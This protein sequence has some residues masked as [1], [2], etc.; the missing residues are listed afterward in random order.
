VLP[1]VHRASPGKDVVVRSRP[2]RLIA[3]VH[4]VSPVAGGRRNLLA[5]WALSIPG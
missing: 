2:G 4:R 3:M 1:R 5:A